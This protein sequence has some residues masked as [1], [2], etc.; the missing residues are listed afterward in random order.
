MTDY[1]EL[2]ERQMGRLD[3]QPL[4]LE[5]FH[6]RRLRKS[7]NQR[8]AAA[9]VG[10]A[11]V[12]A[13]AFAGVSLIRSSGQ[14]PANEPTLTPAPSSTLPPVLHEGE[15]LGT[16]ANG[17]PVAVDVATGR[18]R[19]LG[20]PAC[21]PPGCSFDG[22]ATALSADGR[23]LAYKV[24][25]DCLN[26]GYGCGGNVRAGTWVGDGLG[27]FSQLTD[28]CAGMKPCQRDLFAWSPFGEE[29]AV[30]DNGEPSVIFAY[31]PSIPTHTRLV[32]PMG[33]VTAIAWSPDASAIAY[34]VGGRS[35]G[36][37]SFD[38]A[39]G[40]SVLLT[41]RVGDVT[42]IEWSRDGTRLV[43]DDAIDGR[44]R[45]E[46]VNA[47]GTG[48]RTVVD[49][50]GAQGP[51]SPAWAPDGT[52]IS[53]ATTPGSNGRFTFEVW[54]IG[55]DGSDPTRVYAS[56]C[57]IDDWSGPLWSPDGTRVAF[58]DNSEGPDVWHVANADGSG[59]VDV[60]DRLDV[61]TWEQG[62]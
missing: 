36:V 24:L 54:T 40:E 41:D 48:L 11:V 38:R 3:V 57:C 47:D 22:A 58:M 49:Q 61:Q 30:A 26:P 1:H 6:G 16:R 25:T 27:H 59:S 2:A 9:A 33:D 14:R 31:D 28:A 53:Y 21:F 12:I 62:S 18:D 60:I 19:V 45:I 35:P 39:S 37:F 20:S 51:G 23:W 52:R 42:E 32:Y 8:I 44:R 55:Q 43:L 46:V 50:G 7:R 4:T 17:R 10:L 34:A 5:A 29:L 15:V 13:V 56:D